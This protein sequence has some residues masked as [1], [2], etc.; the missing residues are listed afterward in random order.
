[1][2]IGSSNYPS[3]DI[4]GSTIP[5]TSAAKYARGIRQRAHAYGACHARYTAIRP[6]CRRLVDQGISALKIIRPIRAFRQR[7]HRRP[8]RAGRIYRRLRTPPGD[9]HTGTSIFRAPVQVRNPVELDDVA[10][11]FPA[12]RLVMAHGGRPLYMEEAFFILRRQSSSGLDVSGIPPSKLLE[13]FPRLTEITDRVLW[14]T[15]WPS[16]GVKDLRQNIDQF[17]ALPVEAQQ[18]AILETNALVLFSDGVRLA[19]IAFSFVAL[20]AQSG[21]IPFEQFTLPKRF[22]RDLLGGPFDADRVGR[23]SGTRSARATSVPGRSGFAHLFEHMM[24]PGV[25]AHQKG[26][27]QSAD[28]ACGRRLQRLDRRRPHQLLGVGAVE[29]PQPRAL[30]RGGPDALARHH[31][32]ELRESAAGGERRAPPARG[33]PTL[34]GGLHRRVDVAVRQHDVLPLR[35]T[36]IGSMAD[37]DAAKLPDVQAFFD[38]YY[39]PNNATLVVVGGLRPQSAARAGQSVFRGCAEPCGLPRRRAATRRRRQRRSVAARGA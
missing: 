37:L 10:I 22:A 20:L 27:Q 28:R 11:D 33:Q 5:N 2:A 39:A 36:V 26:E 17:L 32:G 31:A 13:Y 14:G 23:S 35:H 8:R 6:G 3:P 1:M 16:P 9:G 30:G 7:L 38:T 24:F 29:S 25:G 4:M 21:A 34:P 15:D 12:L 18:R 19:C